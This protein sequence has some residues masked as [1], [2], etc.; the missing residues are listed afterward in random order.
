M[1]PRT[2]EPAIA[3]LHRFDVRSTVSE[4]SG[5]LAFRE[6]QR[7]DCLHKILSEIDYLDVSDVKSIIVRAI[8]EFRIPDSPE[9]I[10]SLLQAFFAESGVREFFTEQPGRTVHTEYEV[11][12]AAGRL[13]RFDRIIID[14]D[15]VTIL[16]F[17]TGKESDAYRGQIRKYMSITAEIYAPRTVSGI[18]AYID[19][20]KTVRVA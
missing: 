12:D 1:K 15:K 4:P 6:T 19:L 16:D 11:S 14:P 17:K 18:L 5:A 2:A 8:A 10:E 20:K 9:T 13:Y 7:G 3:P